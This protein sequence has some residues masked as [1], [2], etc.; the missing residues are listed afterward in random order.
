MTPWFTT[1]Y[2]ARVGLADVES[3]GSWDLLAGRG[4]DPSADSEVRAYRYVGGLT[5][6]GTP[7]VPFTAAG[8]GHGVNV[9]GGAL[10][11]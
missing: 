7:F 6:A 11:L 3:S 10:G 2:G 1:L 9:C 5:L 8:Y 4:R